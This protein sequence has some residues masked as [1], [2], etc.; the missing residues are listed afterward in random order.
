MVYGIAGKIGAVKP[1][2]KRLPAARPKIEPHKKT[3]AR[4]ARLEEMHQRIVVLGRSPQPRIDAAHLCEV[5]NMFYELAQMSG[6]VEA[7]AVRP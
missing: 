3:V 1:I 6:L 7:A 5:V 4:R 2:R